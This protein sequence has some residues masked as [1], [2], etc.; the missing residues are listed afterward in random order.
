M[1]ASDV[2]AS[3]N[4][5]YSSPDVSGLSTGLSSRK[6]YS[7]VPL[8]QQFPG[9]YAILEEMKQFADRDAK[10]P[11]SFGSLSDDALDSIC[12]SSTDFIEWIN[13]S[14]PD[15]SDASPEAADQF[16]ESMLRM[17]QKILEELQDEF[18]DLFQHDPA[19]FAATRH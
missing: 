1:A 12:Q 3:G 11:D 2:A 6:P 15:V 8:A 19:G 7:S 4:P 13:N 5:E 9:L 17:N 14:V 18:P 16:Y 10:N